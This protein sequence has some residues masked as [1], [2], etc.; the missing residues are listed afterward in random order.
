MQIFAMYLHL[1]TSFYREMQAK[2]KRMARF[3]VEL[4]EFPQSGSEFLD[5]KVSSMRPGLSLVERDNLSGR[6]SKKV[7][8]DY[9]SSDTVENYEASEPSSTITGLCQD[10][11]PGIIPYTFCPYY[12][13][14]SV[15]DVIFKSDRTGQVLV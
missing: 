7:S 12:P 3:K 14:L 11:C 10:M 8:D 9:L 13:L 15:V 4:T 2:A 6:A 5:T 1:I